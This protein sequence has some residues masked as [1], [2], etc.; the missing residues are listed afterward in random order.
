[1]EELTLRAWMQNELGFENLA[2]HETAKQEPV[3][4]ASGPGVTKCASGGRVTS[5]PA[6]RGRTVRGCRSTSTLR[7]ANRWWRSG[8][9]SGQSPGNE[10]LSPRR[11]AINHQGIKDRP[12]RCRSSSSESPYVSR[13]V[14]PSGARSKTPWSV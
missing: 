4:G 7:S 10:G 3:D 1:M 5:T 6:R 13:K 2:L 14:A 12:V 8:G 11:R 9:T